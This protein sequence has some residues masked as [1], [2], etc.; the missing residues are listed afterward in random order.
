M[1]ERLIV[2]D[3]VK[4]AL[5]STKADA[6]NCLICDTELMFKKNYQH[7]K[8]PCKP[9]FTSVKPRLS[10]TLN[11][12]S[13]STNI[14][15]DLEDPNSWDDNENLSEPE[16]EPEPE[17]GTVYTPPELEYML[18]LDYKNWKIG[19]PL[20]EEVTRL[21]FSKDPNKIQ[22]IRENLLSIIEN[23]VPSPVSKFPS[24]LLQEFENLD[25]QLKISLTIMMR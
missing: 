12:P 10:E 4:E 14:L 21:L 18:K 1:K 6:V 3:R 24:N 20:P 15:S 17:K 16:P 13:S 25:H 5:K 8:K 22:G 23:P 7:L 11:K 2:I 19:T 9:V